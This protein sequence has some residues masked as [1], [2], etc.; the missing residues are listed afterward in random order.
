[1]DALSRA[2]Q[3]SQSGEEMSELLDINSDSNDNDSKD[4]TNEQGAPSS[5][6]TGG[7]ADSKTDQSSEN[8]SGQSQGSDSGM[9]G[10]AGVN[11]SQSGN[12]ESNSN[13][14]EGSPSMSE[15]GGF[16][17]QRELSEL[18]SQ[19]QETQGKL[20][21]SFS[22][23]ISKQG[24]FQEYDIDDQDIEPDTVESIDNLEAIKT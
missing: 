15:Q 22:K 21:S 3:G 8:G 24:G 12:N 13:Q 11:Q 4:S 20:E 17:N 1:M 16:S 19:L 6:N 23:S 10:E 2:L 5:T 14:G 18:F 9:Q 7:E